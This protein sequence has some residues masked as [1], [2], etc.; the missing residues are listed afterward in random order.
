[1]RRVM[2]TLRAAILAAVLPAGA[3]LLRTGMAVLVLA[4]GLSAGAP[5]LL[6]GVLPAR[7]AAQEAPPTWTPPELPL[8]E[9]FGE[10]RPRLEARIAE[11][12]GVVGVV[13]LDPATGELLSIRGNE[14]FPSASVVKL[15][16]LYELMLRVREG[17]LSLDDPMVMLA[18]DRVGG[19]GI[20]QSFTPPA[21]LPVRDVAFLM[22]ALSDNTA[23]NLILEKLGARSVGVRMAGFGLPETQVFR[24]VF[25]DAADSFDPEGS[26]Q[27]GLGVTTPM[28]ISRLLAWIHRGEA[29]SPEASAEMLHMLRAQ[30]YRHGI[31]RYLPEG[32][33]VAH[34]TGSVSRARHD[35]GIVYGPEREYVLCVMTRENTDASWTA[36]NQAEGLI[37]ELSRMVFEAL[38]PE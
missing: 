27:W 33:R 17:D 6:A 34:K 29:V 13:V 38:N 3:A 8:R 30:H 18:G 28:E 16:I 7:A 32:T 15:P 4:F 20:L 36:A 2:V 35:C 24:K 23:T 11:H 25:G 5:L 19:S 31:P 1:M 26:E 9:G 21:T 10:L 12:R 37:A 14:G 22:I